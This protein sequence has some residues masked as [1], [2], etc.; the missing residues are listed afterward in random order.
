MTRIERQVS[1]HDIEELEI[2]N[3]M[4]VGLYNFGET[5][6]NFDRGTYVALTAYHGG[7]PVGIC[8]FRYVRES[9][10]AVLQ[11]PINRRRPDFAMICPGLNLRISAGDDGIFIKE[12]HRSNGV[13][14]IL[15]RT[16]MECAKKLGAKQFI[17]NQ[18]KSERGN[19][20]KDQ[21]GGTESLGSFVFHLR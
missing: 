4:E 9:G 5:V 19:W 2:G 11:S 3:K 15:I 8:D 6:F 20:F 7:E 17:V 12:E 14:T 1:L 13:G 18:P 21:L 16:A 10:N